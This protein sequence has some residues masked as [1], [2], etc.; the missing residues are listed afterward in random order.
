MRQT[1][2]SNIFPHAKHHFG[3]TQTYDGIDDDNHSEEPFDIK[4]QSLKSTTSLLKPK[5]TMKI[6]ASLPHKISVS[7]MKTNSGKP[8]IGKKLAAEA[9]LPIEV[10]STQS[11]TV[12]VTKKRV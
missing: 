1:N 2:I 6:N 8:S 10:V 4:Q 3:S 7:T 5:S 9:T 11:S 12:N